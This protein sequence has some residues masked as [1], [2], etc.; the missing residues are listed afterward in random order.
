M[1]TT[2]SSW[3]LINSYK[4]DSFGN[5]ES[6][7]GEIVNTR[8]FS[9][10]E[11]DFDTGL[12]YNR[13]RYYSPEMGRFIGRDPIDIGDDVNLYRYCGNN[14][15][16]FVDPMGTEKVLV[17][18]WIDHTWKKFMFDK[19]WYAITKNEYTWLMFNTLKYTLDS[20]SIKYDIVF[21]NTFNEFDKT[22]NEKK[23][24]DIYFIWH[25]NSKYISIN[26][27]KWWFFW[28]NKYK[29]NYENLQ[30]D[31]QSETE[32]NNLKETNL[33]L[34]SCKTWDLINDTSPIWKDIQNHY[35]F[36]STTA[37]STTIRSNWDMY[38]EYDN[39][40]WWINWTTKAYWI[41]NKFY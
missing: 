5:L 13:A 27:N 25:W 10:R 21:V 11:F 35:G 36:K 12:Y 30:N 9:W 31:Y 4:Y 26:K 29:I 17:V 15:V 28:E 2:N 19:D 40:P 33:V 20:E 6:Y 1:W 32:K 23:R 34:L 37:P 8:L 16:R 14:G 41:Y 24:D 38:D 18:I 7:V 3:T 22:I 39:W